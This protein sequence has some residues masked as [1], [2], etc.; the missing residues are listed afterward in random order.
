MKVFE[1]F[2]DDLTVSAQVQLCNVFKTSPE[3]E[4]WDNIPLTVI[5]RKMEGEED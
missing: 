5:E 2:Y 4:N 3:K 1:I